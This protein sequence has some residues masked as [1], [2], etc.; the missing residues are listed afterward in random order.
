M[1]LT[2]PANISLT[3]QTAESTHIHKPGVPDTKALLI[4]DSMGKSF[5]AKDN[6]MQVEAMAGGTFWYYEGLIAGQL[7]DVS[8]TMQIFTLLGAN[9]VKSWISKD[10]FAE[11]AEQFV[12][13]NLGSKSFCSNILGIGASPVKSKTGG[14]KAN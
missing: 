3:D 7:L 4:A 10:I 6:V 9:M 5:A 1:F 8:R 12:C 13:D 11:A 14:G 2:A